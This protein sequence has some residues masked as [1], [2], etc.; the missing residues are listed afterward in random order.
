MIKR[1]FDGEKKLGSGYM[2]ENPPVLN[3]AELKEWQTKIETA[4]RYNIFCHCRGCHAQW[5][6]SSF[7]VICS[8]CGSKDV[9]QIS[10]WQFPDD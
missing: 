6:D 7:D 2:S 9:E 5:V 10:C 3:A 4:N 1:L 8:S